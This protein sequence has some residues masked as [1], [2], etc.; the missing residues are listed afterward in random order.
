MSQKIS[1]YMP[2]PPYLTIKKSKFHGL[3]VFATQDI[4]SGEELGITHVADKKNR[5]PD[6]SIR[7]PLGGFINHSSHTNCVFYEL[8]DTWKLKTLRAIKKGEELTA[9]YTVWYDEATLSTYN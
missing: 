5:F 6:G 3:D 1:S 2:L 9:E 4:P 8:E 7:T